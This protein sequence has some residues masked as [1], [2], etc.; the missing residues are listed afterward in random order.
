MEKTFVCSLFAREFSKWETIYYYKPIQSGNPKDQDQVADPAGSEKRGGQEVFFSGKS[1]KTE[2]SSPVKAGLVRILESTYSFKAPLSPHLAAQLE[3]QVIQT[4]KIVEDFKNRPEGFCVVEGAGGVEVPIND[5]EKMK[6]LMLALHLPVLLVTSTRLG[7]IN[8]TLLSVQAL[9]Q[10]GLHCLG[11]VLNGDGK[12]G[13]REV[14]EKQTGLSVLFEVPQFKQ[15]TGK[16][17]D[18]FFHDNKDFRNFLNL[19]CHSFHESMDQ[20]REAGDSFHKS[21]DPCS[22]GFKNLEKLDSQFVWHPFTQHGIVKRHP[23]IQKGEG[24]YLWYEGQKVID[25]ISSWWV[26]L[27]GHCHPRLSESVSQQ[28]HQLEHILFAGFSHEPAIEL[29]KRL[30]QFTRQKGCELS[31]VFF[32]DNGSTSVEVALKMVYQYQQISGHNEKKRFLALKG[33][34]HGD[35]LGAMSVGERGG[36]N[37]VFRSLLFDVD[38]VDPFDPGNLEEFFN[39]RGKELSAVIVEPMVQGASGMRMYPVEFL[40]ELAKLVK[41]YKVM[42]ICDE[43]FTGFYRTGKMFAF[44]HSDLRPDLLCLSKGLTGGYLPLAVT[45]TNEGLYQAFLNDSMK[46]AFLHGHS[47]TANPMACRVACTT[48]ELLMDPK[49]SEQ[50]EKITS[51]TQYWIERL[52]R[53]PGI[54]NARQLGTIGAMEV[55]DGDPHYFKGDFSYHFHQKALAQGVLLRPLGGT[56]YAVPPYCV[57]EKQIESIY[58]AIERIVNRG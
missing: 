49:T 30:I 8:H 52:S 22:T 6:D 5:H 28:A 25:A 20:K 35:T 39:R 9:K 4:E 54:F 44:E 29:S 24:A 34:Y 56:V 36:F 26:N 3:G 11:L 38:F 40:N 18:E 48:M 41:E 47:Y 2:K 10:K 42:V 57:N 58:S 55:F 16:K 21:V 17:L 43:V 45:L 51:H 12:S 46:K 50:V 23:I 37:Q 1:G 13:L 27:F 32:S 15:P 53:N 31:K 7:T 19:C 14:L 33:S